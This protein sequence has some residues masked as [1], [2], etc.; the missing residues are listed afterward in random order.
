[1]A[2][3]T[4]SFG[5]PSAGASETSVLHEICTRGPEAPDGVVTGLPIGPGGEQLAV[6]PVDTP[7][8]SLEAPL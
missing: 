2:P 5:R 8:R 7:F 3:V 6:S 4:K 1:M